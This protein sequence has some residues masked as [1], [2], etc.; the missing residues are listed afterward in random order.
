MDTHT[1]EYVAQS[2]LWKTDGDYLHVG[3]TGTRRA[4][5]RKG[6]AL[7]LKL[8]TMEFA[9]ANGV[10]ELRTGNESNN[11]AML[12]INEAMGFVKQPIWMDFVKT[13]KDE[14]STC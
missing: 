11:R 3:M 8:R 13:F 7:A 12:A 10:K 2:N 4:Y 9:K 6:L 1:G 5:R 14:R